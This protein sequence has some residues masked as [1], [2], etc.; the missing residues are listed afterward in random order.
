MAAQIPI[1]ED[2]EAN[3]AAL[4]K[5]RND[6]LMEVKRGHDGTWVAHPGLVPIAL[7]I[8]DQHMPQPN[9]IDKKFDSTPV[10]PTDLLT[11]NSGTITLAGIR[12]NVSVGLR[13]IESWLRGQGCVPIDH[14]MEDAATAEISRTQLWQWVTHKVRTVDG[15]TV[16]QKL[17]LDTTDQEVKQLHSALGAEAFGKRKFQQAAD[18]YRSML[19]A[20]ELPDFLT[21]IAYQHITTLSP[22]SKL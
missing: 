11:A 18:L 14:L 7:S 17:V 22:P 6:K 19:T 20:R 8:F 9:Q 13:Y 16:T 21:T 5:V 3:R 15:Q 10:S 4:E 2:P 1:K 12:S